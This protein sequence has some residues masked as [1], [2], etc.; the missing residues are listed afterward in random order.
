MSPPPKASTRKLIPVDELTLKPLLEPLAPLPDSVAL[1]VV[2]DWAEVIVTLWEVKTPPTKEP[3]AT[4]APL[5]TPLEVICTMPVKPVTVLLFAS[6]AVI[7]MLKA[8]PAVCGA[9]PPPPEIG[10]S[11]C[12]ERV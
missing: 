6:R 9:I 11:S 7:L 4:G 1:R 2:P 10:R 5:R 8:V 12:R 3:L